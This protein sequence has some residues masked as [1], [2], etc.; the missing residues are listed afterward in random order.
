LA[1]WAAW[2]AWVAWECNAPHSYIKFQSLFLE[3]LL[4]LN[5]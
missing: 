3:A 4:L 2:A 5:P 1:A